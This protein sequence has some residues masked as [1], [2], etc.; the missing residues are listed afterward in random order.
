MQT[1]LNKLKHQTLKFR[2]NRWVFTFGENEREE[3]GVTYRNFN[4]FPSKEECLK[5]E[6]LN[7]LVFDDDMDDIKKLPDFLDSLPSL[8]VLSIPIAWLNSI[9]I[10]QN[11]RA[12]ILINSI[13]LQSKYKWSNNLGLENLLYLSIPELIKPFDIN[14][15]N[16]PNL[17]WVEID[18]KSEKNEDKLFELAKIETL[19]H[20]SFKQ[21]KSFDVFT[22]FKNHK[23]ETLELFS[24]K[25]KKFPVK[26]IVFMKDLKYLRINNISQEFDCNLLLEMPNLIELDILNVKNITNIEKILEIDTLKSLSVTNCSN[27]FKDKEKFRAKNYDLLRIEYS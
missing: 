26:N 19:S 17:E 3:N 23:I 1:E 16:T 4:N 14:F 27:P 7:F 9:K 15:K 11:I 13:D 24:C 2:K 6:S 18:M 8:E 20:L 10:P 21:A 25:G 22:P 12:I 5:I